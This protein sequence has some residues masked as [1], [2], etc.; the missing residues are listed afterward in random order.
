MRVAITGATGFV[1]SSLTRF[2]VGRGHVPVV[3]T[4]AKPE[5]GVLPAGAEARVVDYE[6]VAGLA[7]ALEGC[8]GV[9]NLA[10]AGIFAKRWSKATKRE[11]LASRV[12]TTRALV[13][14]MGALKQRP[15]VFLSGSA[16]GHY[17]PRP[18]GE[19]LDESTA[20]MSE[21]APADFLAHVCFEWERA[22]TPAEVLGIRTVFLRLGVVLGRGGGA[23]AKMLTPFKLGVG[24]RIG[25]GRQDMSWIHLQDVCGLIA[26]ALEDEDLRGPLNL[27]APEPVSNREFAAALGRALGRPAFLPTPGFALRLALGGAASMLTTGQRVLPAKA[28]ACGYAFRF[29][30]LDAALADLLKPPVAGAA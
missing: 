26:L 25:S 12:A 5:A 30:G 8:E 13:D 23:L 9:V 29:P 17:G 2:L 1:G 18:P 16:I 11:I 20:R 24:G 3:L 19:A 10:G 14:A 22:A 4:R 7:K 15:R 27:T 28:L 21:H 6:D